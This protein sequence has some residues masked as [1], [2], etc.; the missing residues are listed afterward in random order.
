[1]F[2]CLIEI[3]KKQN[4]ISLIKSL[5]YLFF[6]KGQSGYGFGCKFGLSPCGRSSG[7]EIRFGIL[8]EKGIN[9]AGFFDC[10]EGSSQAALDVA[11]GSGHGYHPQ[12]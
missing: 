12:Q 3:R 9:G 6:H 8:L 1:V 7:I 11:A 4:C 10:G 5:Q 2:V